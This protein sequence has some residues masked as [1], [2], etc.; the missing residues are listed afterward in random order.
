MFNT[1]LRRNI[2]LAGVKPHADE[3]AAVERVIR[4]AH[5]ED[6]VARLPDG[7][8]TV[9]GEKGMR[10]SGGERQRLGIARALYRQP[11]ILLMDEATSHLDVASERL[12][13][14]SLEAFFEHV[15]AIVI[16][17]R[18]STIQKM[19]RIIVLDKGEI[20]ESGRFDEL[21]AQDGVFA[22]LWRKQR[23]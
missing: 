13:Q 6:V 12:I 7:L 10:L 21:L 11:D 15:T 4:T 14:A 9:V 18:L 2:T 20:A 17:H 8:D 22:D 16:A 5:L 3:T 19:D 23:L 1:S